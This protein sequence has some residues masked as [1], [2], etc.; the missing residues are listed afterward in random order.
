MRPFPLYNE[1]LP[2]LEALLKKL[3][4]KLIPK[5]RPTLKD[6]QPP[7]SQPEFNTWWAIVPFLLLVSILLSGIITVKPGEE[8]V[9]TRLGVYHDTLQAGTHWTIPF[10]EHHFVVDMTDTQSLTTSGL[11]LT[12]DQSLV[13]ANIELDYQ[14]VDPKIYLF[15]SQD[16]TSS[17]Q[18]SLQSASM[19]AVK[20]QTIATLLNKNNNALLAKAI[21]ADLNLNAASYGIKLQGVVVNSVTVPSALSA[22]FMQQ[23][24]QAQNQVKTMVQDA[25]AYKKSIVPIA[26]QKAREIEQQANLRSAA[27]VVQAHADVAE[28]NALLPSYQ[29]DPKAMA[30]YLPLILLPEVK[31]LTPSTSSVDTGSTTGQQNAYNRWQMANQSEID[32]QQNQDQ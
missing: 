2:D 14:V 29:K 8:V 6:L 4:A 25:T 20:N 23:V 19:T 22:Q 10:I 24:D 31:S 11:W 1:G 30:A 7:E 3:V 5:K 21:Y 16:L 13:S 12:Q 28:F 15:A 9:V 18:A 32:A 27:I 17:L 26:N